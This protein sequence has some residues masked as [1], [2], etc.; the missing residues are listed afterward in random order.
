MTKAYGSAETGAQ[1][2]KSMRPRLPRLLVLIASC[3]AAVVF[4]LPGGAQSKTL[5]AGAAG[6]FTVEIAGPQTVS[7]NASSIPPKFPITITFNYVGPPIRPPPNEAQ[8]KF[9]VR[10]SEYTHSMEVNFPQPTVGLSNCGTVVGPQP[11]SYGPLWTEVSCDMHF[12]EDHT[13][14]TMVGRV[15]PS[16][17]LGS[18][19]TSVTL[20]TGESAAWTSEF[21]RGATP[22]LPPPQ[23]PSPP[24]PSPP[25]IAGP[26]AA[27]AKAIT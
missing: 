7:I 19:V 26:A 20:T 22:P 11:D 14:A 12:T 15:R 2:R 10:L 25:P 21:L 9:T 24:P 18:G 17:R 16:D 27:R 3:A 4:V 5:R 23:P 6:N 8:T 13:S 1:W